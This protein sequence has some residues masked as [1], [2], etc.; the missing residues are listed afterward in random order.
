MKHR[1]SPLLKFKNAL[2]ITI[3][4]GFFYQIVGLSF[5]LKGFGAFLEKNFQKMSVWQPVYF[6]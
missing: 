5:F 1:I 3:Q 4:Q 6:L 2:K